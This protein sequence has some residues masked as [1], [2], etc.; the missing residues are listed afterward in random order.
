MHCLVNED[1]MKYSF[2]E[3]LEQ[4]INKM[5]NVSKLFLNDWS[6]DRLI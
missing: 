5:M 2:I 6:Y 3:S 4:T 1:S